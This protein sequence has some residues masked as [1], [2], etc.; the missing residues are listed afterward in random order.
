ML[1]M[2]CRI[3]QKQLVRPSFGFGIFVRLCPV[4]TVN[5][6][7]ADKVKTAKIRFYDPDKTRNF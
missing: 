2:I 7:D 5:L 6:V 1:H 4:Y 3:K